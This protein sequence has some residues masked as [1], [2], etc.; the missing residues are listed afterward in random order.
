MKLPIT[1]IILTY[2]EEVNIEKCLKSIGEWV[3]EILV[4]DSYSTDRT[5]EIAQRHGAKVYEHPFK[6]Q[7]DQFNW[8][9]DTLE[10][11]NEWILRLDADEEMTRELWEE[12]SEVLP[13]INKETTGFLMKR[14]VYFMGRWMR[15]GGYYPTWF[16]RLFKKNKGRS[17]E[18]EVDEHIV[19]SEGKT[20]RLENDFIDDNK[21]DITA[22][23]EKHNKYASREVV[24][25]GNKKGEKMKQR[26]Y[27]G[28]PLFMRAFWYF[29][30]RYVVRAGFLDGKEGL[31]FHFLQGFWY[32]FLVD[33]KI[34]EFKKI[35]N[36][37][38]AI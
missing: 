34:F 12:I 6:N 27:Y 29:C 13:K 7:A 17:E 32:R 1:T 8:A 37:E 19:I 24:A 26:V 28:M 20:Q 10:I 2:N 14:R 36:Y 38:T 5:K 31:I 21:K 22:W 4:V 35:K 30:Y 23:I 25:I 16:V 3:N 11:K 9:L 15:H 18:R 33:V